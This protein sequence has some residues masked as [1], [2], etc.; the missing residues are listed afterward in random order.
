[1]SD[2]MSSKICLTVILGRELVG[3]QEWQNVHMQKMAGGYVRVHRLI[4]LLSLFCVFL[5][6]FYN[7]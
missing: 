7:K 2:K 5:K 4:I 3:G 1:M 6:N